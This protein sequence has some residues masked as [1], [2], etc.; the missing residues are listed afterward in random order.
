MGKSTRTKDPKQVQ[1]CLDIIRSYLAED[2]CK[3]TCDPAQ[4][5]TYS[6]T[7]ANG[8]YTT[9]VSSHGHSVPIMRMKNGFYLYYSMTFIREKRNTVLKG[10]SLQF[11][12]EC[13]LLFRAEWDNNKFTKQNKKPHSQP[14]WHFDAKG[15]I[16]KVQPAET[17]DDFL[18]RPQFDESFT[19]CQE[20]TRQVK[21]ERL[22]LFMTLENDQ[23]AYTSYKD[24]TDDRILIQWLSQCLK[25]VDYELKFI[26]D[27]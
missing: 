9:G 4:D 16:K 2:G 6:L 13:R 14:H 1:L 19:P 12:D 26:S 24:L 3:F 25:Q 8:Y 27:K 20:E 23:L 21:L 17:F 15:E 10:L 11:F 22:H 7:P 5:I 18:R